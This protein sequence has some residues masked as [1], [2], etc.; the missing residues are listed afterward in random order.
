MFSRWLNSAGLPT[1]RWPAIT[2]L[3]A[4]PVRGPFANHDAVHR[5]FGTSIEPSLR[6][7]T[8]PTQAST[9]IVGIRRRDG[10][11]GPATVLKVSAGGAGGGAPTTAVLPISWVPCGTAATVADELGARSPDGIATRAML[12][13]PAASPAAR[14]R[15]LG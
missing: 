13:I 12:S 8:A 2:E 9:P 14:N 1:P 7:P 15:G 6:T 3:P 4:W 10:V 5:L 11:I